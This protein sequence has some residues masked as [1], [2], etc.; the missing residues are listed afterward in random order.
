MLNDKT[1]TLEDARAWAEAN[2]GQIPPFVVGYQSLGPVLP[3]ES[4][5]VDRTL[6]MGATY[7]VY[8]GPSTVAGRWAHPA[9]QIEVWDAV[10]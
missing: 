10:P 2:P 8:A 1:V 4:I 9:G 3:G 6:V 5:E 7:V